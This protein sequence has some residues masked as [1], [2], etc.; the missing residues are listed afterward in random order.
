MRSVRASPWWPVASRTPARKT[1]IRPSSCRPP[2]P[3]WRASRRAPAQGGRAHAFS[4]CASVRLG[5]VAGLGKL[6]LRSA[7]PGNR[8]SSR[9]RSG[10][11]RGGNRGRGRNRSR[12]R[13]HDGRRHGCRDG[14]GNGRRCCD[15][16]DELPSRRAAF[17]REWRSRWTEAQAR[18]VAS[19]RLREP[20]VVVLLTGALARGVVRRQVHRAVGQDARGHAGRHR[21]HPRTRRRCDAHAPGT[22][23]RA[24]L[25]VFFRGPCEP[26]AA[27]S[28][29]SFRRLREQLHHDRS[30]VGRDDA[31][32]GERVAKARAP[33]GAACP[34]RR[35][36]TALRTPSSP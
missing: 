35:R 36:S 3:A 14:S 22:A 2:S 29:R 6:R 33:R 5:D 15:R 27:F 12:R 31:R 23:T 21:T 10:S 25:S 30:D 16:R 32:R 8:S 24:S 17:R 9:R 13:R 11:S 26:S 19:R 7:R 4:A 20:A 34:S 18:S 1:R 28:W